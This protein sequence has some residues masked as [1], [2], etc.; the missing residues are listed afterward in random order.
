MNTKLE[1]LSPK[2]KEDFLKKMG[3]ILAELKTLGDTYNNGISLIDNY[4]W[5]AIAVSAIIQQDDKS[6]NIIRSR[7]GSDATVGGQKKNIEIKTSATG[8]RNYASISM[9]DI[10]GEFARQEEEGAGQ[11][12]KAI[13]ELI[14]AL[15]NK[16]EVK[17]IVTLRILE[18]GYKDTI[19]PI[20]EQKHGEFKKR[21]QNKKRDTI[22]INGTELMKVE[23]A[24]INCYLFGDKISKDD[25]LKML[26][27]KKVLTYRE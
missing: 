5:R 23:A 24:Y 20:L 2:G 22:S 15:F 8:K 13:N 4:N 10:N 21:Y 12:L 14:V 19:L 11:K 26:E 7:H 25:L 1:T 16:D 3:G 17:P 18:K 6:F 27:A 9:S